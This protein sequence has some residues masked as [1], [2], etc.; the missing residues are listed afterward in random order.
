MEFFE[1]VYSLMFVFGIFTES[2]FC[3]SA[4]PCIEKE[5]PT[6]RHPGKLTIELVI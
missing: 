5:K 1:G 3:H 2:H 6:S 4:V